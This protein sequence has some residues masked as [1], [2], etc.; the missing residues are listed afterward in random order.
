MA[1]LAA[2]FHYWPLVCVVVLGALSVTLTILPKRCVL[3]RATG[4]AIVG[5]IC[6]V[7]FAASFESDLG[8]IGSIVIG[9][10]TGFCSAFASIQ[11][12]HVGRTV[13]VCMA[14]IWLVLGAVLFTSAHWNV[15][16]RDD[17]LMYGTFAVLAAVGA[18]V[19]TIVFR[20]NIAN[21]DI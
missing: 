4:M 17:L 1:K 20:K 6:G 13:A 2:L 19:A 5:A 21:L 3:V 7:W 14:V 11:V 16:R 12:S 9:F 15:S 10:F 8:Y 18:T